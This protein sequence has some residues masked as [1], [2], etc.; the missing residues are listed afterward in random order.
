MN[1]RQRRFYHSL[2]TTAVLIIVFLVT[3]AACTSSSGPTNPLP[4]RPVGIG[5]LSVRL[6][7]LDDR[8]PGIDVNVYVRTLDQNTG[9]YEG[10]QNIVYYY[11]V[12]PPTEQGK[13]A[14]TAEGTYMEVPRTED[15]SA[16]WKNIPPGMHTFSVQLTKPD[17]TPL[18]PPVVATTSVLVPSEI[19]QQVP[20]I[21]TM[22]LQANMGYPYIYYQGEPTPTPPANAASLGYEVIINV[23]VYNFNLNDDTIGK[24]NVPG[25]GHLIYYQDVDAPMTQGQPATTAA[26]TYKVTASYTATWTE[27]PAGNHTYSIQMVNNDNTPLDPPVVMKMALPFPVTPY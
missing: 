25:E 10:I 20:A 19:S 14:L 8:T 6:A 11:D 15:V 2:A 21:Q 4:Y 27:V 22:T 18:D 12:T 17:Y 24:A 3:L 1:M 16:G 23:S 13:S 7:D 5:Y 26:D 9:I